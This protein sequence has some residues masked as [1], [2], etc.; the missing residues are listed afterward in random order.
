MPPAFV[1]SQ[2][3]TLKFVSRHL[4]H[5]KTRQPQA[6][7]FKEPIPAL[8]N[9]MDTNE[10]ASSQRRRGARA[11]CGDRLELTGFRSLKIPGPGAVAHM[12][13]HQNRQCQRAVNTIRRTTIEPP[14]LYRGTGCPSVLATNISPPVKSGSTASVRG[15]IWASSGL[16]NAWFAFL[17]QRAAFPS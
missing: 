17:F 5:G 8:S 15:H 6:P 16:V 14:I 2:D 4:R 9:V 7:S 11:G 3:Q 13:L 10:H 12:S 1:L